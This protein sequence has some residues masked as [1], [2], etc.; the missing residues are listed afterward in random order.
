[1]TVL[2]DL[3]NPR[4]EAWRWA[5]LSKLPALAAAEHRGGVIDVHDLWLCLGGPRLLFV[6]GRYQPALS[7]PQG[8][9][10]GSFDITS[11]HALGKLANG[12]GWTLHLD[13]QASPSGPVELLHVAT[14]GANHLAGHI[15]LGEGAQASLVESYHGEGWSNRLT[16][17]DLA[18]EA[19]VMRGIRLLQRGGFVSLRDEAQ[20][21]KGAS[22]VTTLL[23]AGRADTRLDG[24]LQADGEG[25]Y[26]EHGGA[27]LARGQ[28][29]HD[30]AMIV[31]HAAEGG[32]SQQT[33][34]A[35]AD[36]RATIGMAARVDVARD[37]QR[38]DAVQS[39]RGLLL[40]R[41]AA[42][43][44]KPELEIFADDV[45]CAHGATVGE[46]DKQALFYLASRGLAPAQARAVLTRAFVNDALSRAGEAAVREAMEADAAKWLG[47]SA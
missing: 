45:K 35:V 47:V 7:D 22:L 37:A 32:Q 25:A 36:D 42:V 40:Q 19:R 17:I 13:A 34:R 12:F 2:L 20:V 21:G 41:T 10:V 29:R 31:R 11:D 9:E 46:L 18:P 16:R 24:L 28:Q 5:D 23:G 39:L 4:E 43:N 30:L 15:R 8:V 3:P 44:L 6:D 33:W 1:V 14:G 27:L 26:V 38:T